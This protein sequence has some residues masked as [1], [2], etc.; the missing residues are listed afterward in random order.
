M[1][2]RRLVAAAV[3]VVVAVACAPAA[4]GPGINS[5]DLICIL[6]PF[7]LLAVLARR[8]KTPAEAPRLPHGIPE[9]SLGRPEQEGQ[10]R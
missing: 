10:D 8:P 4:Q 1:S 5:A 3:I 2:V 6:A 7:A 9:R